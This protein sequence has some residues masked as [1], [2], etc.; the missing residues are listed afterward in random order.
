M[1]IFLAQYGRLGERRHISPRN[2]VCLMGESGDCFRWIDSKSLRA[3]PDNFLQF[4][5]LVIH[6]GEAVAVRLNELANGVHG[7]II[8]KTTIFAHKA[9]SSL[10]DA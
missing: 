4:E 7:I 5:D 9:T 1:L 6:H 8:F 3:A 2:L 10:R